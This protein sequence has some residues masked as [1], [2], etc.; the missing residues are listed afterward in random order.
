MTAVQGSSP[1]SLG[2]AHPALTSACPVGG[3]T[4]LV[5]GLWARSL[6]GDEQPQWWQAECAGFLLGYGSTMLVSSVVQAGTNALYVSAADS[7]HN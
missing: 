6:L 3:R 2:C 5:A 4:A 1:Q 7:N